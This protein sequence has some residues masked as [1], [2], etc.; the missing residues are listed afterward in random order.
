MPTLRVTD[1]ADPQIE[2]YRGLRDHAARQ[3][4]ELPGGDM[5]GCFISEGD[6][7]IARAL[8]HG[9]SLTSVLVAAKRTKELP[10]A[11]GE[12]LVF[13]ASDDVL[14][15]I[16]G[17]PELRDPLA[18]FVRPE[19][20]SPAELLASITSGT[21]AVLENVNNPNNLGVI[22]RNAAGLGLSAVLLDPT[23][24]DPLYRR[25][26]RASMGQVFALPHTRL[27]P[28]PDSLDLLHA[29][30]FTSIALSP[31]GETS[32]RD[33]A[34]EHTKRAIL[35]GAEGPGLTPATLDA[36]H[37]R[38]RI[39]MAANVDSLNVANAAAIAFH[40]LGGPTS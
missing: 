30:G 2:V 5:A 8:E 40:A 4:R 22:M 37:H 9:Y 15:E 24:G 27:G 33:F 13:Q 10:T 6:L 28:L 21:V 29:A 23:C 31:A 34:P 35:L 17:R 12:A 14:V 1:P 16:T 32:L 19:L 39:D 38:V 11:I 7:V 3:R 20:R 25:A 26:V 18:C 36:S